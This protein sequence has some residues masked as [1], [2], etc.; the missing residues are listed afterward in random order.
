MALGFGLVGAVVGF[1]VGFAV[2]HPA[3]H[4]PAE[5]IR[6]LDANLAGVAGL[7][8]VFVVEYGQSVRNGHVV[9]TTEMRGAHDALV[10]VR[11]RFNALREAVRA[12][13]ARAPQVFDRGYAA[14]EHL[15]TRRAPSDEVAQL[16]REVARYLRNLIRR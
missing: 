9:S 15:T 5:T 12:L 1:V 6:T 16:E 11:A 8:D 7:L 10:R 13:D 2:H 4:D 3:K 14:I